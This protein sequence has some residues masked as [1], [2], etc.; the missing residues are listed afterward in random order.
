VNPHLDSGV[1]PGYTVAICN[2]STTASHLIE[3][4]VLKIASFAPF[5]GG[6]NAWNICDGFFTEKGQKAPGL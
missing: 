2:A 6:V 3:G 5:V 4:A 1:F